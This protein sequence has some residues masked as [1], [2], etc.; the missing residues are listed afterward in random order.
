MLHWGKSGIVI[1]LDLDGTVIA[2]MDKSVRD[3][4]AEPDVNYPFVSVFHPRAD[5]AW[6]EQAARRT[7]DRLRLIGRRRPDMVWHVYT[8]VRSRKPAPYM[9]KAAGVDM[10]Y[11]DSVEDE[12]AA[13]A[14]G[15]QFV[16]VRRFFG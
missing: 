10:Y 15:V 7:R 1:G 3:T 16:E 13:A 4:W 14:A 11:G 6:I 12:Q 9:L 5:A 8:T 2:Y